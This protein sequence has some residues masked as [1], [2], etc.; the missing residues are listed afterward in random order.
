MHSII[1]REDI[2]NYVE[3]KYKKDRLDIRLPKIQ[4][5]FFERVATMQGRSLTDFILKAALDAATHEVERKQLITLTMENHKKFIEAIDNP[6]HPS[7]NVKTRYA[8]YLKLKD[9][10]YAR[11]SRESA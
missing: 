1:E 6:R 7:E 5:E 9:N 4:K 11:N 8:R 2:K 3:E 10:L